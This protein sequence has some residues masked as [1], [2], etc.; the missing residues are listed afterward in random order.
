MHK[1]Y[2][3]NRSEDKK[4]SKYGNLPICYEILCIKKKAGTIH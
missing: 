3:N 4:K 2:K 1:F